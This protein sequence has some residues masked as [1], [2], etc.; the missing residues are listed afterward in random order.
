MAGSE[1][2][3]PALPMILG[4]ATRPTVD[5]TLEQW[6]SGRFTQSREQW[7][8]RARAAMMSVVE[9][10]LRTHVDID[11]RELAS[12]VDDAYP[13]GERRYHPYKMWLAERRILHDIL[14]SLDEA[15]EPTD[16]DRAAVS[17]AADLVELELFADA[18]AL[19][20]EQAPNAL[21]RKCPACSQPV[22]Q[23]CEEIGLHVEPGTL[24]PQAAALVAAGEPKYPRARIVPHEARVSR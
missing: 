10:Y 21:S 23:R 20:R 14:F 15:A 1:R 13:F 16:D 4:H 9:S 8:G 7:R 24:P 2:A 5:A 12:L 22:G 19:L 6:L 3:Q 11:A 18:I 17:V